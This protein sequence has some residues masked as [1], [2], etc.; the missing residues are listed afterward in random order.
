L[1]HE[2][3]SHNLIIANRKLLINGNGFIL[4]YR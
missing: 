4:A 2:R 3:H 1:R